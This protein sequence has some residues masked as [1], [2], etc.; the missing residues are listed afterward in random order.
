MIFCNRPFEQMVIGADGTVL[1]C[2]FVPKPL[3]NIFQDDIEAVWNSEAA[4]EIR[5]SILDQSFKYCEK[6]YCHIAAK[7]GSL[8][9]KGIS[10]VNQIDDSLKKIISSPQTKLI[11]FNYDQSCNLYCASCRKRIYH[12]PKPRIKELIKIQEAFLEKD[13]IK[14]VETFGIA[15]A[16]EPFLS[17]VYLD[18]M[19]R[20]NQKDFPNLKLNILTNGL[21]LTPKMWKNFKNIHY[22]IHSI[23]LSIDAATGSLYEKIR[24]GGKFKKLLNNLEFLA[25]LRKENKIPSLSIRFVVH[26]ENF[27]DMIKFVKLGQKINCDIVFF[28]LIVKFGDFTDDEYKKLAVHHKSHPKHKEFLKIVR[29]PIFKEK[30]VDSQNLKA[31]M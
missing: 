23:N 4:E 11:T 31:F 22:A 3:G 13:F 1:V 30:I 6:A 19:K 21:L 10:R 29:N 27:H 18:L 14:N 26:S 5:N 12:T 15:G 16:G 25:K 9:Q 28:Q 2:C 8:V 7:A 17:K 20:I 24:R